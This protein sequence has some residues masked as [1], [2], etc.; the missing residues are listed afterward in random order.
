MFHTLSEVLYFQMMKSL[1]VGFQVTLTYGSH[2]VTFSFDG[3]S[4][5]TLNP[6]SAIAD[7]D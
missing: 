3:E 6:Y 7:G 1:F 4:L 5:D 2:E